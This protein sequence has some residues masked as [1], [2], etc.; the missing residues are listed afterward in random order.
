[1]S[2]YTY[3]SGIWEIRKIENRKSGD[4]DSETKSILNGKNLEI[5]I[6]TKR[7]P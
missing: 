5:F 4:V 7:S 2:N 3:F 1:M 6:S